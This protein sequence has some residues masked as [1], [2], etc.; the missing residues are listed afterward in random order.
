MSRRTTKSWRNIWGKGKMKKDKNPKEKGK[1]N[2][3]EMAK[4]NKIGGRKLKKDK[5]TNEKVK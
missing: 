3:V 5:N 4:R 1:I 2:E